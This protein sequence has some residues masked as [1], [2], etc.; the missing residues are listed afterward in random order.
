MDHL[1]LVVAGSGDGAGGDGGFVAGD[2]RGL[3]L[4][5]QRGE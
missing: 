4:D 2:L 3:E 1:V 5:G